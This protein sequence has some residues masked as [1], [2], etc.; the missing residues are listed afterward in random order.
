MRYARVLCKLNVRY[1]EVFT[2]SVLFVILTAIIMLEDVRRL[3]L[4]ELNQELEKL[5]HEYAAMF[6]ESNA[7]NGQLY[8]LR[9]A[10]EQVDKYQSVKH[11]F[12]ERFTQRD[13]YLAYKANLETLQGCPQKMVSLSNRL[14]HAE[15]KASKKIVHS[16]IVQKIENLEKQIALVQKAASFEELGLTSVQAIEFLRAN[17][18]DSNLGKG[19]E[20]I[21]QR[22][23]NYKNHVQPIVVQ[24]TNQKDEKL[25]KVCIG[26]NGYRNT[27]ED[28]QP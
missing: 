11:H 23:L 7:L 5:Q 25:T 24:P 20:E 17:H 6:D 1:N 19:D 12:W 15:L 3:K 13:T 10:Q 18:V 27:I 9:Y 8:V 2:K 4:E 22:Y 16:G 26:V 28:M 21:W 14:A